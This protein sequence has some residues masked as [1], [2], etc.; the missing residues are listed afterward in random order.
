M[1]ILADEAAGRGMM[2][3]M[4]MMAGIIGLSALI[5][6]S[7]RAKIVQRNATK[8]TPRELIED[9]KSR[10]QTG[11]LDDASADTTQM[12]EAARPPAAQLDNKGQR[13]EIP[14]QRAD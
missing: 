7:V 2:G 11:A 9:L 8:Q 5:L 3:T 14:L 13:L 10:P 6:I 1:G 4:L 12:I